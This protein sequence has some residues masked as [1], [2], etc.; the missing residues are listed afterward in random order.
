MRGLE[1]SLDAVSRDAVVD[2]VVGES[3][4][5]GFFGVHVVCAFVADEPAGVVLGDAERL[6]S[7]AELDVLTDL[8]DGGCPDFRAVAV[9]IGGDCEGGGFSSYALAGGDDS[10]VIHLMYALLMN[11][12][13]TCIRILSTLLFMLART[14]NTCILVV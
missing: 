11:P 6:E 5:V 3:V 7:V 2:E 12:I 9:G 4:A 1:H 14:H 8:Y 13:Y 10:G